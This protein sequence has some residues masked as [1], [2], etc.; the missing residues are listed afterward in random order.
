L[1]VDIQIPFDT[2]YEDQ[3]E[4]FRFAEELGYDGAGI[5]DHQERGLD[6]YVQLAMAIART[7]RIQAYPGVSNPFTRHPWVLAN[8]ANTLEQLAPGRFHLVI[9]AGDSVAERIGRKGATVNEMREAITTIRCLLR[10]EAIDYGFS[11]HQRIDHIAKSPPPV[12]IAAGGPRMTE[13]AGEVADGAFVLFGLD[14]RI[15]DMVWR[16]LRTGAERTGRSLDGFQLTQYAYIYV[17]SDSDDIQT[18]GRR[19]LT[20]LIGMGSFKATFDELGV[21]R[22]ALDDP[23]SIPGAELD[24]LAQT[25][26]LMGPIEKV[27]EGMQALAASGKIVRLNCS[28]SGPAGWKATAADI[29]G[30]VLPKLR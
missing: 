18:Y 22:S 13:L 2:T 27:S 28:V 8:V 17:S 16:F 1:L 11:G 24:R 6:V 12:V 30:H 10:G 15:T 4:L 19:E 3:L 20:S 14:E 7:Q 26:F 29:A 5:G 9:G 25:L 21:P 23:G